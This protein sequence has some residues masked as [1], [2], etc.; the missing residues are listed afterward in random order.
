MAPRGPLKG[1]DVLEVVKQE[2]E[3]SRVL[4]KE[5]RLI[6]DPMPLEPPIGYKRSLPLAEQI[7]AMVRG[8]ALA[9][10]ARTSGQ[11]TF[12]EA[13]DFNV[14]DD[15]D[16][17]APYEEEFEPPPSWEDNAE[18]LGEYI[19]KGK[20]RYEERIREAEEKKKKDDPGQSTSTPTEA[21]AQ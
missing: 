17:R 20:R 6:P 13:D 15:F 11:E 5:R 8:E 16:P 10:A 9:H 19:E 4:N 21:D 18:K 2:A 1:T 14:D 7:R 12:E 3:R